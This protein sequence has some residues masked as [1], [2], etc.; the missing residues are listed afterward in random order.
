MASRASGVERLLTQA[1]WMKARSGM[2]M[3][4]GIAGITVLLA[5]GVMVP[6]SIVTAQWGRARPYGGYGA[7]GGGYGG[8]YAPGPEARYGYQGASTP[9]YG[10]YPPGGYAAPAPGYPA[11]GYAG[12]PAP[13]YAPQGYPPPAYQQP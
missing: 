4:A 6:P 3:R 7:A 1:G 2:R 12:Y 5:V 10:G 11:P 8:G 13:G 9:A